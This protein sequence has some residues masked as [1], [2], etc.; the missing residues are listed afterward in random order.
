[1]R[2]EHLLLHIAERKTSP[3]QKILNEHVVH[4]E[5]INFA[6]F[7]VCALCEAAGVEVISMSFQSS[8]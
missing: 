7:P 2:F 8:G 1:M 5:S 6:L 3:I 4:Y